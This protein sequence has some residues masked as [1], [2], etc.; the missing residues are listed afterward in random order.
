VGG[1]FAACEAISGKTSG[2]TGKASGNGSLFAKK[3]TGTKKK[4]P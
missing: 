1:F 4:K 3:S 2:K